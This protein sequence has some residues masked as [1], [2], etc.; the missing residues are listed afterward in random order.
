MALSIPIAALLSTAVSAVGAGISYSAQTSAAKQ[1]DALALANM[2]F[3]RQSATQNAA[4]QSQAQMMQAAQAATQSQLETVQAGAVTARTEAE[5]IQA[6][7]NIRRQKAASEAMQSRIRANAGASGVNPDTAS[8]LDLIVGE[9][10]RAQQ[11]AMFQRDADEMRRRA[12]ALDAIGIKAGAV[13]S[14]LQSGFLTAA[15]ANTIVEGRLAGRQATLDYFGQKLKNDA[16]ANGALGGLLTSVGNSA[17]NA[18]QF[19]KNQSTVY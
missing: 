4:L 14:S 12:G 17:L 1:A 10:E 8:A 16:S 2:Q 6:Q 11:D 5:S 9:A 18:F 15:A 13:Q 7:D 3:A 19:R